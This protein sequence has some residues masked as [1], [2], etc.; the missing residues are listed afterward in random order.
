MTEAQ[1]LSKRLIEQLQCSRREADLLIE[2]GWVM[3]DG[4]VVEEPQFK[5]LDQTITVHPEAKAD[6]IEP[7]TILLNKPAGLGMAAAPALITPESRA[8][9]DHSQIRMLKK[10]F[11][12]LQAIMP[13][14]TAA[15]GLCVFSQDFRVIRKLS[16][17][18]YKIEH[19]FVVEVS[20]SI[21]P[22]GLALLNHGL[23]F[24]GRP[25]PPIKVSWQNETRLRFAVKAVQAG[26]I[27][28]M[29]KCVGLQVVKLRRIRIG[30]QPM[31]SLQ[32]GQWRY[33]PAHEKF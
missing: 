12:G 5:V 31:A 22:D 32:P 7:I 18:A 24:Q 1:R 6:P 25:L 2:G 30:R 4:V 21:A 19:E 28:Y 27:A 23:S 16:E 29:C 9:E 15:C 17:D 20:G 8:A 14:E 11:F 33:L 26:Q 3:V 13:L 10:H